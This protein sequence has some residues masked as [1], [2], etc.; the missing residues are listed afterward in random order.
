M[1]INKEIGKKVRIYRKRDKY[2]QK[3]V[4]N[5][6][7]MS[8]S[9]YVNLEMGRQNFIP[10][11]IYSLCRIFKCKPN[12]LFPEITA[13]KIKSKMVSKMRLR[14]PKKVYFKIT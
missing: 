14:K 7:G 12:N 10:G 2:Q 3:D 6:L 8:R 4:A 9:N 5:M 13:V 1:N 11:Y